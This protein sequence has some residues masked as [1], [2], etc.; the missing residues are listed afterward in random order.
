[1]YLAGAGGEGGDWWDV[2]DLELVHVPVEDDGGSVDISAPGRRV[3]LGEVVVD[4]LSDDRSFPHAGSTDDCDAQRLHHSWSPESSSMD[5]LA[6]TRTDVTVHTGTAGSAHHAL[7]L[8][9]CARS[10]DT[11]TLYLQAGGRGG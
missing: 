5:T 9:E 2:Q 4:E 8:T 10:R 3:H 1:M 7:G 6:T 11:I